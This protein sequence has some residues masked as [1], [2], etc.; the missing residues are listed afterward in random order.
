MYQT[1]K[2]ECLLDGVAIELQYAPLC[3]SI[4]I[5][6]FSSGVTMLKHTRLQ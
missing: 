1:E 3:S 4:K 2:D 6:S 5:M